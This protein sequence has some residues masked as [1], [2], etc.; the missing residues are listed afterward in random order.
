MS[1]YVLSGVARRDADEVVCQFF[2]H[3]DEGYQHLQEFREALP[4]RYD[5]MLV[6]GIDFDAVKVLAIVHI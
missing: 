3:T 2:P 4:G 5:V 1:V 6:D